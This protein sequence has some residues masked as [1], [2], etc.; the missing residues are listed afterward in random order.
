MQFGRA[1]FSC[2]IYLVGSEDL[3]LQPNPAFDVTQSLS[4]SDCRSKS[5]F[6]GQHFYCDKQLLATSVWLLANST[7]KSQKLEARS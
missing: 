6:S 7:F 3:F 4:Y 5:K 1:Q 2:C